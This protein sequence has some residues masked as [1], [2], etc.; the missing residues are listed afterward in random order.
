MLLM[1]FVFPIG[2][3]CLSFPYFITPNDVK[4]LRQNST[5]MLKYLSY[6]YEITELVCFASININR[7]GCL[8]GEQRYLLDKSLLGG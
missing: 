2:L 1:A 8:K 6:T 3:S 4:I 5:I 7:R